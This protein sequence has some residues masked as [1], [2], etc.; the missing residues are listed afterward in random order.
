MTAT[1]Q[2]DNTYLSRT[3]ILKQYKIDWYDLEP[4]LEANGVKPLPLSP[5]RK[6]PRYL[7]AD[8]RRIL[9]GRER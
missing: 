3:Q 9:A 6:H 5:R 7:A 4:L 1:Q 2:K 8:I